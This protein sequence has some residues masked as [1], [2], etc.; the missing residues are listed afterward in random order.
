MKPEIV[1]EVLIAKW[2]GQKPVPK[3]GR[4]K[5]AVTRELIQAKN[6]Y[7]LIVVLLKFSLTIFAIN[8]NYSFFY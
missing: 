7:K 6:F 2:T 4:L 1:Q 8:K 5:R 3:N